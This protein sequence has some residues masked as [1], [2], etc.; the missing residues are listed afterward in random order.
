MEDSLKEPLTESIDETDDQHKHDREN[1]E[2][3]C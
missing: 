1:E 2:N 3:T